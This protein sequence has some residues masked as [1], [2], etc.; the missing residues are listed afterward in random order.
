M[1]FLVGISLLIITPHIYAIIIP[2][3]DNV[4]NVTDDIRGILKKTKKYPT[5]TSMFFCQFVKVRTFWIC[6]L[7]QKE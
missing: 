2:I 3:N 6:Y 4:L 5:C 1:I 7:V